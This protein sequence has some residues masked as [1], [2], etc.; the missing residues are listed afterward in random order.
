MHILEQILSDL[1]QVDKRQSHLVL[2][3]EYLYHLDMA[4]A[5][6]LLQEVNKRQKKGYQMAFLLRDH[7]LD[8]VL[9]DSGLMDIVGE[10]NLHYTYGCPIITEQITAFSIKK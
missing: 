9:Q 5:E 3:S 6:I 8:D 7:N 2:A 10:E 1:N 4:G